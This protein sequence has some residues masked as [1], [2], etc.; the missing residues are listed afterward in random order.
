M[1][2]NIRMQS[3]PASRTIRPGSMALA[4]LIALSVATGVA[5]C[6][7]RPGDVLPPESVQDNDP[8]PRSYP[9]S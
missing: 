7:K 6:G 3:G 1:N 5:A 2:G 8:F 9:G 4:L